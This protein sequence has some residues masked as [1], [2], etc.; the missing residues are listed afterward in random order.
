MSLKRSVT[1]AVVLF[2]LMDSGASAFIIDDK[3]AFVGDFTVIDFETRGEEAVV[4]FVGR[5]V[6]VAD[7]DGCAPRTFLPLSSYS[8]PG[9]ACRLMEGALEVKACPIRL[10]AELNIQATAFVEQKCGIHARISLARVVY[11]NRG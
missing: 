9:N 8:L 4:I 6:A 2:V 11:P 1:V 10:I 5:E 7:G 3:S